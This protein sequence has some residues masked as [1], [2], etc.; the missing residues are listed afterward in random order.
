M[1]APVI[2]T[3]YGNLP[4]HPPPKLFTTPTHNYYKAPEDTATTHHYLES[5]DAK[6]F[7]NIKK[8]DG[9]DITVTNG[10]VITP[11]LQVKPPPLQNNCQTRHNKR[12]SGI[13]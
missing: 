6:Y 1:A 4:H 9:P 12:S 3:L 8:E 10:G 2:K 7:T 11:Y 13:S 5:E